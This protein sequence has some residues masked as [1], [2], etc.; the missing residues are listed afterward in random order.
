MVA[1]GGLCLDF[2]LSEGVLF[3][4]DQAF[5]DGRV[6]V[7]FQMFHVFGDGVLVIRQRFQVQFKITD[8]LIIDVFE[9]NPR[10]EPS[11]EVDGRFMVLPG[12]YSHLMARDFLLDES[13]E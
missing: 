2:V 9:T 7:P 12:G 11:E 6:D 4:V 3:Q 13:D 1:V 10:P 8:E 5:V